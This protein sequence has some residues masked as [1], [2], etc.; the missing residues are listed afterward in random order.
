MVKIIERISAAVQSNPDNRSLQLAIQNRRARM[1]LSAL[2]VY[3]FHRSVLDEVARHRQ[4][5]P[6]H[7]I[8]LLQQV[9]LGI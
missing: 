8:P 6:V 1:A 3:S 4:R 7:V 9:A 5:M 2:L